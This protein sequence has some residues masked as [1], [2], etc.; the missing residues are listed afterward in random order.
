MKHDQ[1]DEDAAKRIEVTHVRVLWGSKGMVEVMGDVVKTWKEH[2]SD[3]VE[4]SGQA[5]ECGHYLPEEK[6]EEMVDEIL[7][8][9][10]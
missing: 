3:A 4:V 7:K 2:C 10:C 1:A 6:P 9:M 5:L 8:F